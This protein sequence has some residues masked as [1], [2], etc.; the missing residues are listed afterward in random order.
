[1]KFERRDLFTMGA[2][3]G[4]AGLSGAAGVGLGYRYHRA[5]G[6]QVQKYVPDGGGPVG[7]FT[8]RARE[9]DERHSR[10]T[11]EHV[12]A[13]KAKYESPILGKYRVWDLIERLGLCID[14]SDPG[15]QCSSQYMHVCQIISAMEADGV[16][17]ERLYL[18]ALLHDVGKVAMLQGEEPE[19]V[20]CF[21]APLEGVQ[22]A[23]LD[24]AVFQ[25]GH[26]EIAYSR[27]KDHVD[28][29]VA[30]VLR[31]HSMVLGWAE[32]FM[33]ES[34][35]GREESLLKTFRM[36]DQG[37]KSPAN[38]PQHMTLDRYRDFIEERFPNPILF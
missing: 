25:F 38:R 18:I 31:Y 26:D 13:L 2:A 9:I 27:F 5:I 19:D 3:A 32:P 17:D 35:R 29:D 1:M 16:R 7:D 10:Q 20:V 6:N 24:N 4:A 34:D 15:L 11:V 28:E 12:R 37:T 8:R 30:W 36:Y 33:N 22:G 23:G 21:I 14:P